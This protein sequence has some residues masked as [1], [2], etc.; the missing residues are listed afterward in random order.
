MWT[1]SSAPP[2]RRAPLAT[3]ALRLLRLLA[4]LLHMW[5]GAQALAPRLRPAARAR[6]MRRWARRL[7]RG[8][9][10]DV[11][12]HG[13]PAAEATLLVANHVSW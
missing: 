4:H 3:R 5:A 8:L 6:L 9:A 7:L 10:V 11:R 1:A 13:A 2:E 12:L